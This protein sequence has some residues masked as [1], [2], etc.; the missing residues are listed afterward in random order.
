MVEKAMTDLGFG[1]DRAVLIGDSDADM[2]LAKAAGLPGVK[3]GPGEGCAKDFAE[4][5][6]QA[7]TLFN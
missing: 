6:I 7:C 5:A 1:A 2:G 4:A 3:I